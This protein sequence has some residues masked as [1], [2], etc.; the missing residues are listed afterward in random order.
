MDY[1]CLFWNSTEK[2]NEWNINVFYDLAFH[3]GFD[4]LR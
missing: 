2:T 4:M 1:C 3:V